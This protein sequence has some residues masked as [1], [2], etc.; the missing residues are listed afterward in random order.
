MAAVAV[1]VEQ[2]WYRRAWLTWPVGWQAASLAALALLIALG[3]L[4]VAPMVRTI[5]SDPAFHASIS[6]LAPVADVAHR[7]ER[8]ARN[9]EATSGAI[10]VVWRL[11]MLPGV[12]YG[13]GL[14][15]LMCVACAA[16]AATLANFG[17][18]RAIPR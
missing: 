17:S 6:P 14:L 3:S 12:A 10:W 7:I 1:W 15:A 18:G 8:T 2:P 13:Y 5:V 9:A 11:V 4:V 16:F